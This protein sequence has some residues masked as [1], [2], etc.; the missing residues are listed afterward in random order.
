RP[1]GPRPRASSPSSRRTARCAPPAGSWSRPARARAFRPGS[2]VRCP[3]GCRQAWPWWS[4][5]HG[6]ATAQWRTSTRSSDGL[7]SKRLCETVTRS[8]L[9]D[10]ALNIADLIEHAVDKSPERV[11]LESGDRVVTYAV[12]DAQA[13]RLAHHLIAQG[14]EPGDRVGLYSRNTI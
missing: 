1:P 6:R 14:V 11:A 8:S 12:L 5:P 9:S 10:V 4:F 2:A 13:N 7:N 3:R